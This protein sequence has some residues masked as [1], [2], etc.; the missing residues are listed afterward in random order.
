MY[1][2]WIDVHKQHVGDQYTTSSSSLTGYL[3][4]LPKLYQFYSKTMKI[5]NFITI[6]DKLFRISRKE[7]LPLPVYTSDSQI[8]NLLKINI[9]VKN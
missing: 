1:F 7:I 9:F 5:P 4:F 8:F 2:E 6:S 3:Q